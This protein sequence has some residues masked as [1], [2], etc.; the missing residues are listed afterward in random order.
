MVLQV[1]ATEKSL[2][3][4]DFCSDFST[5]PI[6]MA[7]SKTTWVTEYRTILAFAAVQGDIGGSDDNEN[8]PDS[9]TDFGAI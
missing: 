6:L 3:S 2:T 1:T 4:S 9:L 7:S 5:S 8:A